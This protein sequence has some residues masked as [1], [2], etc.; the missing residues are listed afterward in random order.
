[1]HRRATG[2][3]DANRGNNRIEI[4]PH[5]ASQRDCTTPIARQGLVIRLIIN[6]ARALKPIRIFTH[7]ACEHPGYFREYLDKRHI[8]YALIKSHVASKDTKLVFK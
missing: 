2:I 7:E 3:I 6:G 8:G 4:I 1:M 5:N